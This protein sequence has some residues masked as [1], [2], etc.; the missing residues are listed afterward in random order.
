MIQRSR[1]EQNWRRE[2]RSVKA[3]I[4][5]T[6]PLVTARKQSELERALRR[7]EKDRISLGSEGFETCWG[8]FAEGGEHC[9]QSRSLGEAD[10]TVA[11]L[12]SKY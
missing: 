3:P 2:S 11:G 6:R 4:K 9:C 10:D 12:D 5:L 7:V 8:A 1:V